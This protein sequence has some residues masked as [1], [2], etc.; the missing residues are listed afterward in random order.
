[1]PSVI[2]PKIFCCLNYVWSIGLMEAERKR[3]AGD[4]VCAANVGEVQGL[5]RKTPDLKDNIAV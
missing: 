4:T 2:G 5:R 1:M 3:L